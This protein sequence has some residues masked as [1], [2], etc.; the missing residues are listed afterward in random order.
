MLISVVSPVLNG[1]A[2]LHKTYEC[3]C[4]QTYREWEW[5]VVDDGSTDSSFV[6][7]QELAAQDSRVRCFTQQPSGSAKLPR[8]HAVGESKGAFIVPLDIDD[9]LADDYL[10]LMLERQQQTDAD[11]VYPRMVFVDL[12]TD[13]TTLEL[14]VAD[15]DTTKVYAGRDLVKETAPEWRIGCNGGLYRRQAWI[16]MSWPKHE[17]PIWMNSD[18]VDERLYQLNAR[19]VAFADARYYYQN[20]AESI[21]TK[22]SPKLFHTQKTN[23][24][25][26]D[27]TEHEFGK[28]SEEHRRMLRRAFCD[29]RWKMSIYV[30]HH[31][32]LTE[33]DAEI[34]Q[35]LAACFQRLDTSVLTRGER[36][37]FFYLKSFPLVLALFCLKYSPSLLLKKLAQRVCPQFYRNHV[38]RPQ[39]ERALRHQIAPSYVDDTM[40]AKPSVVSLF[41]G[42][43]ESG[44][45]VDRLRGAVSTYQVCR[46]TGRPFRLYFTHPFP[47]TDYLEPADYDWR[48]ADGEL[49]F[50][51]QHTVPVVACAVSGSQGERRLQ[52]RC[53]LSSL[54]KYADR[55][56]HVYTNAAFCYDSDFGSD[57]RTLFQPTERLKRHVDA[58]LG[59]VGGDYITV[60]AR[61]C[62]RLDD[63]NEEVYSEPLSAAE[64]E[65][66][67]SDC[68]RELRLLADRHQGMRVVVCSDSTTFL[69]RA[70]G[71]EG[72]YIIPG[73]ISHIG[74][75]DVHDYAYYEK[76]F[77]DFYVIAAATHV[78]LLAGRY[79]MRSGFPYAAALIGNKPFDTIVF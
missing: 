7:L 56:V 14:P 47:L 74:N 6:L 51:R 45:L 78:Y 12:D 57:F 75:D 29:W 54:R 58:V 67:I 64:R 28:D 65:A 79:M 24:Q 77:L 32:E 1:E 37:Q 71:L 63:S 72:V 55:Q 16:N 9:L 48:I 46:Q 2:F 69:E 40:A 41:C 35:G 21:T 18:E 3:L 49:S 59:D 34:H 23:L 19:R 8:D 61:F 25:L 33:A 42:N 39:V 22:V 13:Q 60:S 20:H 62:N 4:R 76:T 36:L 68:L 50:S 17:E 70:K 66:L 43:A 27:L 53:L 26:L 15:F 5:V 10:E 30:R 31:R 73:T 38:T 11:I 52:R 44:G